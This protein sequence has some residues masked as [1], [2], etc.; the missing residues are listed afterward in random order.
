MHSSPL[1]R[2]AV[3]AVL[4]V[5]VMAA[6]GCRWFRKGNPYNQSAET[7]PLE[8]P[9]DLDSPN[10]SAALGAPAAVSR[11][12]VTGAPAQGAA[13]ASPQQAA[14][15]PPSSSAM[16][17]ATVAPA[18]NPVT[19]PASD[20]S[21]AQPSTTASAGDGGFTVAGT[22]DEVFKRVGEAL[23]GVAGATVTGQA[24]ASGTFDVDFEGSSVLVRVAQGDAGVQV[25][26]VDPRGIAASGQGPAKLMAALKTALGG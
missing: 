17:P 23:A 15:P 12:Q 4:V 13:P 8:I 6:S 16:P 10:T 7:R 18:T 20:P 1:L 19:D 11:S 9:P 2:N 26:A 21:S 25:S 14:T 24:Q 5:T 3:L 22:R